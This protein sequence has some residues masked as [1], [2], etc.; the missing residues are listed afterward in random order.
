MPK[1]TDRSPR[2]TTPPTP[3]APEGES[4]GF[5]HTHFA[6][7]IAVFFADVLTKHEVLARFAHGEV[8]EVC[9]WLNLTL[10]FNDG[11]AFSFLAGAGGVQTL[12][13][14]GAAIA[15]VAI[16]FW[17]ILSRKATGYGAAGLAA[18][19]GGAAGNLLD[20]LRLGAVVDFI[21]LHAAGLHW[22]A[23]N[24]ADAAVCAG[25]VLF[26]LYCIKHRN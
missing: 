19:A 1:R 5:P 20:R 16:A 17:W 6:I 15:A 9:S 13:F 7:A 11:A 22:P 4:P 8:L 23:F 26:A 24:V 3:K 10:V 25:A 12:L 2:A 14:S 21:D 18:L